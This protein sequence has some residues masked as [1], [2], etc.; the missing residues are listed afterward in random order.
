MSMLNIK[1]SKVIYKSYGY[2]EP[3]TVTLHHTAGG[4][5]GSETYL[6]SINLGYHFM[7]DVDGSIYAYNSIDEIV[8]HSSKANNGYVGV[9]YVAGGPLGPVNE[10]QLQSSKDL[11][12][13]LANKHDSIT[14][15]S[16]H[17]TIDKI[18][19]H[20]GWKSDP[21]WP[22]EK[23][24]QNDW[25]IKKQHLLEIAEYAGLEATTL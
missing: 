6:K 15:V 23:A 19:A 25:D 22:G 17:A 9:S 16:D 7:I 12:L 18:V 24:E 10:A 3:H 1:Q 13:D 20:R 8:G 14:H 4:R 2:H 11:L 5:V 21:Q